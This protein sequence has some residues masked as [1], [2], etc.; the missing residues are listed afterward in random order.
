MKNTRATGFA[1]MAEVICL[2]VYDSAFVVR[3]TPERGSSLIMP[4]RPRTSAE[5]ATTANARINACGV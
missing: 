2:T 4:S 3:E 5:A 1:V